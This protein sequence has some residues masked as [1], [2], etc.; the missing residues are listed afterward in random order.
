MF[1]APANIDLLAIIRVGEQPRQDSFPTTNMS[2]SLNIAVWATVLYLVAVTTRILS[3]W[4]EVG[5]VSAQ[6]AATG[7]VVLSIIGATVVMVIVPQL[8]KK[9]EN[10]LR[11]L[12]LSWPFVVVLLFSLMSCLWSEVPLIAFRRFSK[13]LIMVICVL[14]LLSENDSGAS[15]K[16]AIFTYVAVTILISLLFV[17]FLPQYGW[18]PYDERFLARGILAHKSEFGDFCAVSILL[19][20]WTKV[21]SPGLTRKEE[22]SLA[23]FGIISLLLL[24]LS[25]GVNPAV[26]LCLALTC[27]LFGIMFSRIHVNRTMALL[28]V[29]CLFVS[30]AIALSLLWAN[31]YLPNLLETAVTSVGKDMTFTGRVPLWGTLFR[32]GAKTHP[33]LGYG[34]GSFFVSEKS[35]L[36]PADLDWAYTAHCGYLRLFMEL[37][38][39]GTIIFCLFLGHLAISIFTLKNPGYKAVSALQALLVYAL[40][41]NIVSDSFLD[42][43]ISFLILIMLSFYSAA[44]RA[45][46]SGEIIESKRS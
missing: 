1:W 34:F 18:M 15:L 19:I 17:L 29:V 14:T 39:V 2:Y 7:D 16:R 4:K 33:F 23:L 35:S 42:V 24:Y 28:A 6:Q 43:R 3:F 13:V 20:L 46:F 44:T 12:R 30:G 45:I 26:N 21:S 31:G 10:A 11:I 32:L 41:Y 9:K 5:P 40:C 38:I 36:L 27:F 37:G 8:L 25:Q 22:V